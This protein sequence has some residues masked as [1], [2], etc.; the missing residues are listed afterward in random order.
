M[1]VSHSTPSPTVFRTPLQEVVLNRVTGPGRIID[2]GGGGEGLVARVEGDRVC[3]VDIRMD[4]VREARIH[5]TQATWVVADARS[6]CFRDATFDIATFWF[7]LGFMPGWDVKRHVVREVSRVLTGSGALLVKACRIDC[8][9]DVFIFRMRGI[10]P[11]GTITQVGYGM[12]GRQGQDMS[13][14][15]ALLE[16]CD[17]HVVRMEDHGHWFEVEAVRGGQHM[18]QMAVKR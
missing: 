11:D 10:L 9:T 7:S 14:T 18:K 3:A 4:E 16:E 17:F 12:H 5:E 8:D 2:I 6:L 15:A 13:R 1:D